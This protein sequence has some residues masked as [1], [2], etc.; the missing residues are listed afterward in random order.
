MAARDRRNT[1]PDHDQYAMSARAGIRHWAEPSREVTD[2]FRASG[3]VDPLAIEQ[4]D[5][6]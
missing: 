6:A 1:D 2:I 5:N 4:A 3:T